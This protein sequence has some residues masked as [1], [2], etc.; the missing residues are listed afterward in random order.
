MSYIRTPEHRAM[1][2]AQIRVSK[3]WLRSTGPKS[4][5]GKA[6]SSRNAYKGGLKGLMLMITKE[7][8]DH[9]SILDGLKVGN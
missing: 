6:K 3:P 4:L 8:K 5:E 1:R 9:L 2:A 7:L